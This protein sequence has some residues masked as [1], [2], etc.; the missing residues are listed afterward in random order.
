MMNCKSQPEHIEALL[1]EVAAVYQRHVKGGL[2]APCHAA[3]ALGC[4]AHDLQGAVRTAGCERFTAGVRE[5]SVEIA[6]AA[7]H[8]R[9]PDGSAGGLDLKIH[10]RWT[11]PPPQPAT[12]E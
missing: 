6:T 12:G 11:A 8:H 5:G 1:T 2:V 10:V 7:S 3:V 9:R 4:L